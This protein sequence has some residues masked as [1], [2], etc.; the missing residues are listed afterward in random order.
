MRV[1][2]TGAAGW[3]GRQLV[4]VLSRAH[5]LRLI[6]IRPLS[7]WPL[8]LADLSRVPGDRW[9]WFPL[10]RPRW[11]RAFDQADV[12]IHLAADSHPESGW[13]SIRRHNVEATWNVIRVATEYRVKRIVFA[14]SNWAVKGLEQELAPG[15][16]SPDGPKIGSDAPPR[17]VTAYGLSKAFGELAGR[18]FVEEGKLQSFIA[19]RIGHY[20][21]DPSPENRVRWISTADIQSLFRRS[22]EADLSGFHVVYG[23]SAQVIA[24]YDLS[25]TRQLLAWSPAHSSEKQQD[26]PAP[27]HTRVPLD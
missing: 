8:T 11:T 18:M 24:P 19:I 21:S 27:M 20:G 2:I 3:I 13:D 6:D 23:V 14:S 16:Y 15:C 17:P 5:A 4:A 22:I 7:G 26:Q 12:V 25:Y 1:V 9:E 10:G